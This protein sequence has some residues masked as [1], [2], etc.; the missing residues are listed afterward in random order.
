MDLCDEA[1]A[2]F[3]ALVH[4]VRDLGRE[5]PL[6]AAL[7]TVDPEGRPSTRTVLVKHHD[8]RG[9]VFFTN[10]N[11]RKGRQLLATRHASLCFYWHELRRQVLVD[12]EAGAIDDDDADKYWRTRS[13]DAQ[14]AAWASKQSEPLINRK[15]LAN[16]MKEAKARFDDF[17]QV[18]RPPHWSGFRLSPSRIEF[19]RSGWSR[20]HERVCYSV[21]GDQWQRQLLNP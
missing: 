21:E 19:W 4:E 18:P 1:L 14:V 7:A 20:L 16:S 9:F 2:E 3:N 11:S 8:L 15:Q 5:E 10:F 17:E 13:R 12:G 6:A